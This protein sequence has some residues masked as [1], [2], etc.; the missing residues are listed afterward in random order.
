MSVSR[1]VMCTFV[2][3]LLAT[4]AGASELNCR[5]L[6]RITCAP[7]LCSPLDKVVDHVPQIPDIQITI[8]ADR[9]QMTYVEEGKA[10]KAAISVET[11]SNGIRLVSGKID[12]P[13]YADETGQGDTTTFGLVNMVFEGLNYYWRVGYVG[14]D[15][16]QEYEDVLI[17]DCLA[18]SW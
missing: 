17:G 10:Q 3:S 9:K 18:E 8:S 16:S 4:P 7:D 14:K 11:L 13:S 2:L 12:W 5:V 1:M 6:Y 15:E